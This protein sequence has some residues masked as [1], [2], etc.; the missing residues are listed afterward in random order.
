VS[1]GESLDSEEDRHNGSILDVVSLLGESCLKTWLGGPIV[2]LL[3]C[4]PLSKLELQRRNV[5]CHW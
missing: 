2:V 1:S 4:S 3:R 5:R